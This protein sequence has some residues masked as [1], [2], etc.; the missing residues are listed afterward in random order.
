MTE[1]DG[2]LMLFEVAEMDREH[3]EKEYSA[4]VDKFKPKLTTDD[5]YTPPAMMDAIQDWVAMT[6]KLDRETFVRPFFPGGDYER[7]EY[8]EGCTVVDNPPFSI[9]SKICRFYIENGVRFFLFAPTLT[10]F[11]VLREQNRGKCCAIPVGGKITYEN[12]ANVNTSFVTNLEGDTAVRTA[13]DLWKIMNETDKA[14]QRANVKELPKYSYPPEILTAAAAYQ[15]SHYG[16]E[17]RLQWSECTRI[18][19]MDA[20]KDAG[21]SIF[22]G[23]L[24]LS[25]RAA[26][27]RAAAE[28]AAAE[29]A[30]AERAAATRWPL[31]ERERRIVSQ[32]GKGGNT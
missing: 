10:L 22:G 4:F 30:A 32:L 25:E 7:H 17:Y 23:G 18:G 6:Y 14:I 13:P 12:G 29:R 24:I 27:E 2:Q 19:E 31:S 5:C 15:L 9:L 21:K 26:A 8:P 3:A 1:I 11:T 16:Q 28:R 20:Q